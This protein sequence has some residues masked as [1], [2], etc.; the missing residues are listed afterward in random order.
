MEEWKEIQGYDGR[1]EVSNEGRVRSYS[2]GRWG[3]GP[4][5]KLL[6]LKKSGSGYPMVDLRKP[7]AGG[8]VEYRL[9][10]RLVATAFIEN[11]RGLP[12]VNHKDGDKTNNHVSNLEWVTPSEN[13]YHAFRTG[14]KKPSEKQ[15]RT[16]S[17]I[18]SQPVC[19]FDKNHDFLKRFHSVRDAHKETGADMS[20]IVRC[21]KGKQKSAGGYM[22]AYE[23]YKSKAERAKELCK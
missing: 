22:W 13:A 9:V 14:L 4:S 15:K 2:N 7:H 20:D 23:N 17:E 1:Y 6:R 8:K 21:C 18:G 11:P 12:Q 5:S 10:H 3:N 19:M 16:A